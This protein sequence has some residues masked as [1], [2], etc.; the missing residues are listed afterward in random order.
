MDGYYYGKLT[1]DALRRRLKAKDKKVKDLKK[2]IK[3]KD[4]MY[5]DLHELNSDLLED[6]DNLKI[7]IKE[8]EEHK[9]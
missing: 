2:S 8:L 9:L 5:I 1:I 4:K 7:I 3:I 6:N